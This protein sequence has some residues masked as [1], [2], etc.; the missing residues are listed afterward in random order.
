MRKTIRFLMLVC[1]VAT[2]LLV[3]SA[4]RVEAQTTS[5]TLAIQPAVAPEQEKTPEQAKAE[6][7][8][9]SPPPPGMLRLNFRGAPLEAVLDYLSKAAGFVIILDAPV[10]G[11]LDVWSHQPLTK[12]EAVELLN[13][14]LHDKGY[15]AIR[16]GRTLKIVSREGARTRDLPVRTGSDPEAIPKTD[17]MITQIIP[18]QYANAMRLLDN[19][20]QLAP[21]YAV[22]TANESSNAIVLTDTQTNVRRMTEIVRALDT[23]I[24]N[25]ATVKVFPLK[26]SDAVELAKVINEV[27]KSPASAPSGGS[28]E[29][30]ARQFFAR[31]RGGGGPPGAAEES[32]ETGQSDARQ[33]VS[34]VV[35]VADQRTNS[36][37]VA[38]SEEMMAMIEDV[39]HQV[40]TITEDITEVRV[41]PLRY[42][43]AE[44]MA[45]LIADVF[46]GDTSTN[47]SRQASPFGR[48]RFFGGFGRGGGSTPDQQASERKL[49]EDKVVAK[50]DTRTNSVVVTAASETMTQIEQMVKGLDSN[51][52]KSQKVYV[53]PLQNADVDE[54]SGILGDMFGNQNGSSNRTSSGRSSTQT[55]RSGSSQRGTS[56]TGRSQT[57]TSGAFGGGSAGR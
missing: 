12:D 52:A 41:F 18:V 7:A 20:K 57:E 53:Y 15:A 11:R 42:A 23:S 9:E 5:E 44:E 21:D 14:V 27:F 4:P 36:V 10:D 2:V 31:M 16:N 19:L 30:R 46:S 43:N 29:E 49:Q 40:D 28:R 32:G 56:Q 37:V 22:M 38:A 24:A 35:A 33:A 25:I 48:G 13:T 1:L 17:E 26:H 51:P 3:P 39:I 6:E 55:N 45:Q 47:Q 8:E 50:A 34:R 54:V